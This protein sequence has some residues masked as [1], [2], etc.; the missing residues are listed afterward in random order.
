MSMS[1]SLFLRLVAKSRPG[2]ASSPSI[3]QRAM[4]TQSKSEA[5]L[6]YDDKS[7]N[8]LERTESI[9][10]LGKHRSNALEL[11]NQ[12]PPIEV[13]GDVAVCDGGGGALG[14][15]LEYIKVG[16]RGGKPVQCIYCALKFVQKAH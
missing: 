2:L 14:H 12:V 8:R 16:G 9:Y 15:P 3:F 4:A 5:A 7:L 10:K 1:T 11:V 6:A 13:E